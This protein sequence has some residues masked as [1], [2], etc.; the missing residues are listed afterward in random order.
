MALFPNSG[1]NF[2]HPLE[3][4]VKLN[5]HHPASN[6]QDASGLHLIK[7]SQNPIIFVLLSIWLLPLAIDPMANMLPFD[8]P[9]KSNAIRAIIAPTLRLE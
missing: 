5:Q 3:P 9:P 7:L 1:F 2:T 6:L 8:L 4:A